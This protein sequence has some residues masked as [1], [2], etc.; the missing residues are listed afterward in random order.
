MQTGFLSDFHSD[1]LVELLEVTLMNMWGPYNEAAL[2]FLTLKHVH[3]KPPSISQLQ[4]K[5]SV[6]FCSGM[7]QFSASACLSLVCWEVDCPET[8]VL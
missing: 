5:N 2:E 1:N 4:F 6:G 8:S 7:L 3:A